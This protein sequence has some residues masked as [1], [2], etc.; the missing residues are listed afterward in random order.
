MTPEAPLAVGQMVVQVCLYLFGAIGVFGGTVQFF[1]GQPDTSPRLDNVHRFMAGVYFGTGLICL[2][3]AFTVRQQGTLV[4]LIALG[5]FLAGCG[6][7]LSMSK[8]GLP[9]PRAVWLA[10]LAPELVLPVVM[11]IAHAL[12]T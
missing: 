11:T 5:V 9:Q 10:Y 1:L 4:Y 3:A 2:W 12:R 8:V 6:R 7:L